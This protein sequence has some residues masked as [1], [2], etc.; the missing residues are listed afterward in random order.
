MY[1]LPFDFVNVAA[2]NGKTRAQPGATGRQ[3]VAHAGVRCH[4]RS[5]S[6][7][8][9]RSIG[10]Y[11]PEKVA[12]RRAIDLGINIDQ[13]V[14][15]FWRGQAVPAQSRAGAEYGRAIRRSS[16]PRTASTT[17]PRQGTARHVRL[18]RS[19]RRRLARTP[20]WQSARTA[21]GHE[22]RTS[23]RASVTNCVART[24]TALGI[25]V[26]FKAAKWPENL[27]NARAGKLQVWNLG[28][29][30]SSR[31]RPGIARP[32]RQQSMRAARTSGTFLEQALRR[33][34]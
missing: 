10:G 30:G 23:D 14:R 32:R 21:L 4:P 12:L 27:R 20:R 9:T 34:L 26:D 6:T 22:H 25:K 16:C 18:R 29:F 1:L 3:D 5:T 31:G 24:S 33:H 28:D 13:E 7:C 17:C 8:R 11:E 19:R 15:L 2:P